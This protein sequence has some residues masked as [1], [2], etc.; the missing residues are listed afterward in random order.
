MNRKQDIRALLQQVALTA[1]MIASLAM[2][3]LVSAAAL[4]K[5]PPVPVMF[6]VHTLA[7]DTPVNP[8]VAFVSQQV[9]LP[10]AVCT[11]CTQEDHWA[12]TWSVSQ[13]TLDRDNTHAE[14]GWYV[15]RSGL[16]GIGI[17]VQADPQA[18]KETT[19]R[20]TQLTEEGGINVGLVRLGQDTGAGLADL[21]PTDY[22]RITTFFG[23]DGQVKYVQEDT[24]HVSADLRI[25]T[26]TST[27]GSLSF[28]LPDISQVWLRHNVN[29]GNY[30]D[31][32]SSPL[33]LVVA[34]CSENIHNVRIRFIPSGAVTD[35]SLGPS[36]IL[37]GRDENGQDTGVGYLM[38][39]A[40]T[41]F[42]R[43]QQGVVRWEQ[44]MPLV[45]TNPQP[46]ESDNALTQG[47]TV[48][49]QAF[50][51]RPLNDKAIIAGKITA[52]GLYQVSYD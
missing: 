6:G 43:S 15:F 26:C 40:A 8:Q 45:L 18:R 51:A 41:G 22:T 39:Y 3:P 20:G 36:T 49:L 13:V 11:A 14:Q 9:K 21:P 29:T 52:K 32:Q 16:K 4:Q 35:S 33:Q 7:P 31:M 42:G 19:G 28:Q 12:S 30:A 47:I 5:M 27:A 34:N 38:K 2:S 17:S 24:I 48:T 50:Y 23:P 25:P 44:T 10:D 1:A 37:V 46:V